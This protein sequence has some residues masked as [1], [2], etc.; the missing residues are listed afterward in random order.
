MQ[1]IENIRGSVY[2]P[3]SVL[4]KNTK[5]DGRK[6]LIKQKGFVSTYDFSI[7]VRDFYFNKFVQ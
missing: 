2:S 6:L 3:K 7:A 1:K 5:G 4:Y